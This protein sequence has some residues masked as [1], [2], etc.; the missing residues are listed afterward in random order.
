MGFVCGGVA[1]GDEDF[2]F[3][4]APDCGGS[5]SNIETASSFQ[6]GVSS[7]DCSRVPSGSWART[8]P[9]PNV[10]ANINATQKHRITFKSSLAALLKLCAYPAVLIPFL[11]ANRWPLV[12]QRAFLFHQIAVNIR[13]K[14]LQL[15]PE[16]VDAHL[17]SPTVSAVRKTPVVGGIIDG[18]NGNCRRIARELG[19]VKCITA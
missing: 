13:P 6:R 7:W 15:I 19:N 12:R 16:G 2:P 10:P 8:R 5:C 1:F 11:Q 3:C 14:F 9:A 4:V 18:G 17:H